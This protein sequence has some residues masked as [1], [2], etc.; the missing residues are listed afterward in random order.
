MAEGW[1]HTETRR[2][3]RWCEGKGYSNG[4]PVCGGK[5][6][7]LSDTPGE[8]RCQ[9]CG[10][11]WSRFCAMWSAIVRREIRSRCGK[12]YTAEWKGA[13]L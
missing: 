2:R 13:K 5:A 3:H 4:A 8:Q 7:V 12:T 6:V 1:T 10:G 11:R 9:R